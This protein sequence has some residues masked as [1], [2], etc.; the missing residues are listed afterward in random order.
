M[1]L[2]RPMHNDIL[3]TNTFIMKQSISTKLI[4]H[5]TRGLNTPLFAPALNLPGQFHSLITYELHHGLNLRVTFP[6][7]RVSRSKVVVIDR[8]HQ[9]HDSGQLIREPL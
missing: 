8:D 7:R 4:T 3:V 5:K 9:I 2:G 6:V 1:Q